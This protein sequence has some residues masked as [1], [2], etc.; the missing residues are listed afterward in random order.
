MFKIFIS[1]IICVFA[2]V[3][4]AQTVRIIVPYTI[5]GIAD[6][7][8]RA[9]QVHLSQRLPTYNFLLEHH[10]GAGGLIA[11][12]YVVNYRGPDTLL[13]IHSPA[14]ISSSFADDAGYNLQRDFLPIFNLGHIPTVLVSNSKSQYT[15]INKI[16]NSDKTMFYGIAGFGGSFALAGEMLK[17]QTK[18]DMVAVPYKGE[19]AAFNDILTN[20]LSFTFNSLSVVQGLSDSSQVVILGVSG[21]RRH[22][23]IPGVP[24]LSEQG[25]SG[26]ET[27]PNWIA[28]FTNRSSA[29][30]EVINT[31]KKAL[32]DS[33]RDS[34]ESQSYIKAGIDIETKTLLNSP[35]FIANETVRIVQLLQINSKQ[36]LKINAR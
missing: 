24:T 14:I 3:A 21:T 27:S 25:I 19:S 32:F 10:L 15:S 17:Q 16:I 1:A 9:M 28:L 7:V 20:N 29:N 34:V 11:S 13:L 6:K 35:E 23:A 26:F 22:P 2:L 30:T 36:L 8:G 12:R 18:K 4:N 31:I 5:G 33:Y